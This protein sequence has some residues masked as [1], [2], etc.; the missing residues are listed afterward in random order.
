[1]SDT[2]TIEV[3]LPTDLFATLH[4]SPDEVS[5]EVLVVAVLHWQAAGKIS[6]AVAAE[7]LGISRYELIE[8]M[9]G[10]GVSAFQL[11]PEELD[12]ECDGG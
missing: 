8:L 9:G 7:I 11:R 3:P 5:R 6:Q 1:M 4:M 12:A 10:Y 2:K